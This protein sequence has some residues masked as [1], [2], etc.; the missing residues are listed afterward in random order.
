M[1]GSSSWIIRR[2]DRGN[3]GIALRFR[4]QRST[5]EASMTEGTRIGCEMVEFHRFGGERTQ[6]LSRANQYIRTSGYD[7]PAAPVQ[8]KR[9]QE[10]LLDLVCKLRYSAGIAKDEIGGAQRELGVHASG[11]LPPLRPSNQRLVQ[12]DLVTNAAELW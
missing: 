8:R 10:R 7:L 6:L 1:P 2:D 11:F 4:R 5:P 3:L 12:I 9:D